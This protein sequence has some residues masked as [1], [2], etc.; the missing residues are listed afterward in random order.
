VRQFYSIS[1]ITNGGTRFPWA[2]GLFGKREICAKCGTVLPV[3][4]DGNRIDLGG[5]KGSVWPDT[6][7]IGFSGPWLL[8]SEQAVKAFE[9]IG[10]VFCVSV[11]VVMD[12]VP[13]KLGKVKCPGYRLVSVSVGARVSSDSGY[14]AQRTCS[15]CGFIE[16]DPSADPFVLKDSIL[17]PSWNGTALFKCD[18]TGNTFFCTDAIIAEAHNRNL[19][20]LRFVP[21]G[22]PIGHSF[23][24]DGVPYKKDAWRD[25]VREYL[26]VK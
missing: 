16:C 21:C 3:L 4:S 18:L 13:P 22:P 7:G 15:Q 12:G 26:G 23:A 20:G 6:I 8:L 5:E 1:A 11:S 14:R 25:Y 19:C 9:D 2:H 10:V 17:E 24:F